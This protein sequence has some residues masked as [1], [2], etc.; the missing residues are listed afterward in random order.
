MAFERF[1]HELRSTGNEEDRAFADMAK[2]YRKQRGGD[3]PLK[4]KIGDV[5]RF[6]PEQ[7]KGLERKGYL[8]YG[9]TGQT[10]ATLRDTGHPF[11]STWHQGEAIE[12]VRSMLT[13][14]AVNPKN[15]FLQDSNRKTLDEQLAM[16]EKFGRKIAGEVKGITA[17]LGS[18][19]DYTE[20]AFAHQ[21]KRG[22][23]LFGK[24]F[25]YDYTRTTTPTGG[26][27]VAVVGFF[28]AGGGLSVVRWHRAARNG[29]LW[30]APLVV[31]AAAVGR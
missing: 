14:V 24:D 21:D 2:A 3:I 25:N 1:I 6:S 17:I 22:Q 26:S 8:V 10:I 31:P 30:A 28:A 23:R 12:Q 19:P 16:V 18:A 5:V 7:R 13:E 4:E 29:G 15:L 11:W 27:V 20:L 9:L